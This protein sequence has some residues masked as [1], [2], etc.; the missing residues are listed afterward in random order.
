MIFMLI[1]WSARGR[2][3]MYKSAVHAHELVVNDI[4][5]PASLSANNFMERVG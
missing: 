4:S 2:R 1:H 3:F 5:L